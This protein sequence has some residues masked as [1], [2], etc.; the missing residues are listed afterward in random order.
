MAREITH[1]EHGPDIFDEEDL[2]EHGGD[3]AICRCG[4]S[5]NRPFCDGSHRST[6]DEEEGVLYKYENDD[7]EKPRHEIE[8]IVFAD[9]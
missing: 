6:T 3:I 5:S 8:E 7:N 2:E 4:L 9:D 1:E